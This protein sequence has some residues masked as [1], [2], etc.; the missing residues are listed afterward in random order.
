MNSSSF[1][2]NYRNLGKGKI[3]L[4]ISGGIFLTK[5][6]RVGLGQV[7]AHTDEKW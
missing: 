7:G 4:V 1:P 2:V 6:G 5:D 3:G